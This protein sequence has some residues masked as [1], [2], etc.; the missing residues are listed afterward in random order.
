MFLWQFNPL[1]LDSVDNRPPSH[2]PFGPSHRPTKRTST[3]FF[4]RG[5]K[6]SLLG[7]AILKKSY[8]SNFDRKPPKFFRPSAFWRGIKGHFLLKPC[9]IVKRLSVSKLYIHYG[10]YWPPIEFVPLSDAYLAGKILAPTYGKIMSS[11][12]DT[13]RSYLNGRTANIHRDGQWES[14]SSIKQWNTPFRKGSDFD[15]FTSDF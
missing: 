10:T 3:F 11:C 5:G 6:K 4:G 13:P 2:R 7:K 12:E 15:T 8:S 1:F 9:N 14:F